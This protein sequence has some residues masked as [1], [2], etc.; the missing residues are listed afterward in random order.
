MLTL[1]TIFIAV[2]GA[3]LAFWFYNKR[4]VKNLADQIEDK[5]AV[6]NAFRNHVEDNSTGQSTTS[7]TVKWSESEV[8]VDLRSEKKK[9]NNN[10]QKKSSSQNTHQKQQSQQPQQNSEKKNRPKPRRPKTQQ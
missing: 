6:I 7:N 10:R 4:Q 9:K 3:G 2:A 1:F 8:V 5:N